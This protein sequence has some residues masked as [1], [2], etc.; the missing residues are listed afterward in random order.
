ML[1]AVCGATNL[2]SSH[3]G[4]SASSVMSL[5][6]VAHEQGDLER[7]TELYEQSIDRYREGGDKLGLAR[8]LNNLGLVVY[9]LGDLER[10]AILTEESVAL[11]RELEA[12]ADTAVV[13][14]NLGWMALF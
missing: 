2:L 7:A 5:A 10:A 11:L 1:W 4:R 12:G 14:S 3:P 8:C 13:L 9:S 6:T